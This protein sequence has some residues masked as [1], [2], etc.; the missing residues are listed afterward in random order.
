MRA[1][2]VFA[3]ILQIIVAVQTEGLTRAL[4]EL[5][6]FLLVLGLVFSFKQ[7]KRAQAAKDIGRLG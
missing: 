6:A 2:L 7:K 4:A 3:V 5:S 1:I